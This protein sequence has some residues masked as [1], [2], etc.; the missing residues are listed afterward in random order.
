MAL[1]VE[2]LRS[3]GV[4]QSPEMV[5][6]MLYRA[7]EHAVDPHPQTESRN[8]LTPTEAALA[9]FAWAAKGRD[10]VC[11]QRSGSAGRAGSTGTRSFSWS[12]RVFPGA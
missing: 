11:R 10:M 1:T 7:I 6:A 4:A 5:E 3:L 2:R 8:E 12:G 9:T